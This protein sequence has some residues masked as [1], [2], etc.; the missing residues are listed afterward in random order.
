MAAALSFF[1]GGDFEDFK[2]NFFDTLRL[3]LSALSPRRLLLWTCL[4]LSAVMGIGVVSAPFALAFLRSPWMPI[5]W[6]WP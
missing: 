3:W 2:G 5:P 1:E 4:W 6:T